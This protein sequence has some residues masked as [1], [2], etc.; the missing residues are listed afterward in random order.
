MHG[1]ACELIFFPALILLPHGLTE[2]DPERDPT[3][4]GR[5]N[6]RFCFVVSFF[7]FLFFLIFGLL[8]FLVSELLFVF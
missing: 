8:L 4:F 5:S 6:F 1:E 7:F 2:A 3:E